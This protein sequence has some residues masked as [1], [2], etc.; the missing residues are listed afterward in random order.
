MHHRDR[1]PGLRPRTLCRSGLPSRVLWRSSLGRGRVRPGGSSPG[2][3]RHPTGHLGSALQPRTRSP[4]GRSARRN[5]ARRGRGDGQRFHADRRLRVRDEEHRRSLRRLTFLCACP[6]VWEDRQ[7]EDHS[8]VSAAGA[9]RSRD[10]AR[11][12]LDQRSDAEAWRSAHRGRVWRPLGGRCGD[13]ARPPRP[14][15]RARR[16]GSAPVSRR[17]DCRA[18]SAIGADRRR[19]RLAA[20]G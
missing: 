1:A 12:V 8:I 18:A 19:R 10:P 20:V 14:R 13:S 17:G 15:V 6:W 16:L 2:A 7:A 5:S 9:H 3:V 4:P 11:R